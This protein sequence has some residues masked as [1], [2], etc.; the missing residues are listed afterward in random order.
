M[1]L[2]IIVDFHLQCVDLQCTIFWITWRF[3][4]RVDLQCVSIIT[5]RVDLACKPF[6]PFNYR[7]I[8]NNIV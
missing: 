1:K 3:T 2:N 6:L 4:V 7:F 5:V 8:N